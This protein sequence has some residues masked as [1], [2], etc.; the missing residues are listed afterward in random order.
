MYIHI[1]IYVYDMYAN[2]Q[3]QTYAYTQRGIDLVPALTSP[4]TVRIAIILHVHVCVHVCVC[5]QAYVL[6]LRVYSAISHVSHDG[7]GRLPRRQ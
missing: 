4:Y 3:R 6:F 7:N 5:S 1:H 2:M